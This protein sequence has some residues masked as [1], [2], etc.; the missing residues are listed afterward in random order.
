MTISSGLIEFHKK[1]IVTKIP[2]PCPS[3]PSTV[4]KIIREEIIG[5]NG[6]RYKYLKQ[7]KLK[8]YR[9]SSPPAFMACRLLV[10]SEEA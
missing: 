5:Q 3:S 9:T 8:A 10:S 2:I 4:K 7:I 6:K 1:P